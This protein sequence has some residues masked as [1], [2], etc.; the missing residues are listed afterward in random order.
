MTLLFAPL[1]LWQ[2]IQIRR[3][4]RLPAAAEVEFTNEKTMVDSLGDML[5]L[6]LKVHKRENFLGF[7]FEICTFS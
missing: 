5:T 6:R 7:D 1:P 2:R 4:V 3:K